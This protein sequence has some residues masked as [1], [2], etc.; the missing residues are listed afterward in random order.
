MTSLNTW[1]NPPESIEGYMGFVYIITCLKNGKKYIGQKRFWTKIT[2]KPLKGRKNKRHDRKESN[3]R[4]YWGSSE[5][6][7]EDVDTYGQ[8][9]FKREILLLCVS[10]WALSYYETKYQFDSDVLL[11]DE[12]YNGIINCRVGKI[13]KSDKSL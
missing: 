11:S 10:K 7:L 12:Y 6:L 4:E 9:N 13:P 5:S 8:E 1:I 2:R 3:W